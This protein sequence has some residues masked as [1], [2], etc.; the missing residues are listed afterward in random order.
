VIEPRSTGV[1]PG[2]RA[3]R[4]LLRS[5]IGLLAVAATIV[6]AGAAAGPAGDAPA[7][8]GIATVASALGEPRPPAPPLVLVPPPAGRPPGAAAGL[9]VPR[10][11]TPSVADPALA[12][13]SP[14]HSAAARLRLGDLHRLATG[15]GQL[16][17]VIDTGVAPHPLLGARLRGGGDYLTGGDGLEDCDGHGTAVA[18]LIAAAGA[19]GE[20]SSTPIGIA[21]QARL[22]AIR[23][24][25]PSYDVPASD[26]GW[27]PA[28]D[29]G[30][31]AE[32]VVL[33][34]R[35]GA[36]VINISEAVCLPADRAAGAGA[37]LQA[38]LR[39]AIDS[40]V[41]VVAAAGNVG[42][43]SCTGDDPGEVVLPGWYDPDVLTVGAVDSAGA[44]ATFT[45]PGPWVDVAAPGTDLRSLAVGGGTTGGLDGTSFATPWVAGL[46]ALVRERYP[47]LTAAEVADRILATARRTPDVRG[48]LGH[49]VVDPLAALTA[50]PARLAPV[51]E[52]AVVAAAELPGTRP[53]SETAS[54]LRW[55]VDLLATGA[56]LGAAGLTAAVLRRRPRAG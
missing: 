24:S 9:R 3:G 13:S 19:P 23:Q 11:C 53:T 40:D 29:T 30:T 50:T 20:R 47:E 31:L 42:S 22:L 41:V 12:P 6:P 25:S 32:A 15:R 10:R 45:L 38:A 35:A 54:G 37:P 46:A 52:R 49:G 18:G 36:D 26:G 56:L 8:Q 44:A 27:R 17:A 5:G 7:G 21:P 39:Y 43:G 2:R 16:I 28:G 48:A 1:R 55:P 51:P 14:D 33:A 34:V 4:P